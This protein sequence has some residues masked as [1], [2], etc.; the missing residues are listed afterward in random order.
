VSVAELPGTGLRASAGRLLIVDRGEHDP[1]FLQPVKEPI[2][3]DHSLDAVTPL[4]QLREQLTLARY[5]PTVIVRYVV[6]ARVFLR[7][8]AK[9][10]VR[11]DEVEPAHVSKH[12]T[13]ELR[14]YRQRH[15]RAPT[16]MIRWR[17]SHTAG[18]HQLLRVVRGRWP[19]A[20]TARSASEAYSNDLLGEFARWLH[21][22][23]GLA[24]RSIDVLVAEARRFLAWYVGTAGE[25]DLAAL[26]LSDIDA[27]VQSR[28][29]ALRRVSRKNVTQQLR[30]FLKFLHITGRT[31]SDL[32]A[33]VISPMLYTCEAMPSLLD[34]EQIRA[35]LASTRQDHSAKGRRDYA[36]LLLLAT[37]GLRAGE[38][39]QLRLEDVDWHADRLSVRHTKTGFGSVLPLVPA[40]GD[41]LLAYL[42]R[43][44]PVTNAREVFV[45]AKAPYRP[46]SRGSSLY[47]LVRLRLEAAGVSPP[48][49]CGPHTFRH[50]RAVSLLR[51][52]VVTKTIGD[53]LGHRSAESTRPYLKLATD[54]LREVALEIP[55]QE[56]RA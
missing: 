41:A 6:F 38:I 20:P 27:Y 5:A 1:W 39:A 11:L 31:A 36:I 17:S 24:V 9:R 25:I 23:R 28:C 42:R 2:M 10:H 32:A 51:A 48:G 33:G 50:A 49:K 45:H 52:S 55:G 4:T 35:V 15:G 40:V 12:L 37:Y 18:I 34:P 8:L 30:C 13:C 21:E 19:I 43:G 47:L 3:S 46:F 56:V 7:Y 44:R 14:R 54:D 16:S 53:L 29:P 26:R 22:Q